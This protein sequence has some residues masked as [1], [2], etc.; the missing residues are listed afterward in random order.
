MAAQF[1]DECI[2]YGNF[3]SE[4]M[5]VWHERWMDKFG[6]DYK[7]SVSFEYGIGLIYLQELRCCFRCFILIKRIECRLHTILPIF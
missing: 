4:V 6:N 5:R 1:L 7:W 3:D 2:D